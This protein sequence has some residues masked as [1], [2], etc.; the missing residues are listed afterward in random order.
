MDFVEMMVVIMQPNLKFDGIF[1]QFPTLLN[2]VSKCKFPLHFFYV[3]SLDNSCSENGQLDYLQL[4]HNKI[5]VLMFA[6]DS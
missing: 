6:S 3:I 4:L 5:V 2:L 1:Q